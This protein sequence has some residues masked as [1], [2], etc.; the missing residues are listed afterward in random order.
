MLVAEVTQP[1]LGVG[2]EIGRALDM[3]KKILCLYRP[4]PGKRMSVYTTLS[5]YELLSLGNDSH[6]YTPNISLVQVSLRWFEA[7]IMA[8][9]WPSEIMTR[10]KWSQFY[11][12][13]SVLHK[14][15]S[16]CSHLVMW[17]LLVF[18]LVMIVYISVGIGTYVHVWWC[19]CLHD[20]YLM[21]ISHNVR[22]YI[23]TWLIY[24]H[25]LL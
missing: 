2:Y 13:F 3:N 7:S 25:P 10:M 17:H 6:L 22:T 11:K 19:V 4:Q 8:H 18:N 23:H 5:Q 14:N 16:A 21:A 12:H 20:I 1:S 9:Q 24:Q 15:E